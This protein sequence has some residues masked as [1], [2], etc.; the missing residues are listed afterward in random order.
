M[1]YVKPVILFQAGISYILTRWSK[2]EGEPNR[3]FKCV[4]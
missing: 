1:L 2:I 4:G 3:L